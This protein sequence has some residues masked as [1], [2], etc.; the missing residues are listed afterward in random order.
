MESR[1]GPGRASAHSP[2]A[3]T[4]QPG[5]PRGAGW[6]LRAR[7]PLAAPGRHPSG[8]ASPARRPTRG[9]GGGGG[10]SACP[11]AAAT[12]A[13]ASRPSWR[14]L[15]DARGTPRAARC[16]GFT[17][18][19]A[20]RTPR[21]ASSRRARALAPRASSAAGLG[22]RLRP[23]PRRLAPGRP[24]RAGGPLGGRHRLLA[25][26]LPPGSHRATGALAGA[27]GAG[28]ASCGRRRRR[29]ADRSTHI[30]GADPSGPRRR[31]ARPAST[32]FSGAA[33]A[34]GPGKHRPRRTPA[35]RPCE[36][37]PSPDPGATATCAPQ[38]PTVETARRSKAG[39]NCNSI[40]AKRNLLPSNKITVFISIYTEDPSRHTMNV[41][42]TVGLGAP[43]C[44]L[45][46]C[47]AV[48]PS[49]E[50]PGDGGSSWAWI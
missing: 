12:A 11:A 22:P 46:F 50:G 43:R 35:P 27:G 1:T 5:P 15:A 23:R 18:P 19:S 21:R 25:R 44:P 17:R 42:A 6:G 20:A 33:P 7:A 49:P 40:L 32:S 2:P 9:R 36:P 10:A 45:P 30:A 3:L 8:V 39:S 34:Q 37:R 48:A 28:R 31:D 4:R 41:G 24:G 29:R 14:G 13:R 38:R 26:R 16:S 47:A